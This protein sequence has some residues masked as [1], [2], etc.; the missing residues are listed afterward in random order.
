M[1]NPKFF[2]YSRSP[3]DQQEIIL[4]DFLGNKQ[5]FEIS[6]FSFSCECTD[7]DLAA[8][9]FDLTIRQFFIQAE[10]RSSDVFSLGE[11]MVIT[12][13]PAHR[14][15]TI[16]PEQLHNF[17]IP[18]YIWLNLNLQ[19]PASPSHSERHGYLIATTIDNIHSTPAASMLM[20]RNNGKILLVKSRQRNWI[21][22]N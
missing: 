5:I 7:Q 12:L 8:N 13:H 17:S 2:Q 15:L 9:T 21:S 22:T 16:Y 11:M 3:H 18:N 19:L 14:T 6:S 4:E 20:V 10:L 1:Q